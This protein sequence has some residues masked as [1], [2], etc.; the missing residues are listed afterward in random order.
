MDGVNFIEAAVERAAADALANAVGGRAEVR[1]FWR[2]AGAGEPRGLDAPETD[3]VVAVSAAPRSY[4]SFA[5]P[6]AEVRVGVAVR[7]R[8]DAEPTGSLF[9]FLAGAATAALE[10]WQ[11]S[12]RAVKEDFAVDGFSPSGVRMDGG[13]AGESAETGEWTFTQSFTVCGVLSGNLENA[14]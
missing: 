14:T 13:E 1:A 9:A 10:R 8:R 12:V 3:A 4:R 5:S 11:R 2:T 7:V 6:V